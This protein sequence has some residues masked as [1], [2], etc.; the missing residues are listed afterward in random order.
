MEEQAI[1]LRESKAVLM[2]A[3]S[4]IETP[5]IEIRTA[6]F[7]YS[8]VYEAAL[9]DV[10]G[11]YPEYGLDERKIEVISSAAALHD[12]GK[13]AIPDAIL[14][15]PGRLT[16]GEFQIM[17]TH[18]VKGYEILAGLDR[19]HDKEYLQY[20]YNIC[21]YHH[22]TVYDMPLPDTALV[23]AEQKTRTVKVG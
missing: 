23:A 4:R 8:D 5:N 14:N 1:N 6:C 17:K 11:N 9:E 10:K 18:A 3:L 16:A 22:I 19:M 7:A 20:A 15:K 21:R 2:D 13:I 12:I